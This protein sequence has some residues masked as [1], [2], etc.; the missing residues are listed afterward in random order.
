M[1]TSSTGP[2]SKI[3]ARGVG[4]V[5]RNGAAVVEALRKISFAVSPN[6]FVVLLGPSGCGKSTLLRL[7]A[8]FEQP[9]TGELLVDGHLVAGTDP[10]RGIV[11]QRFASFPWL[12]VERNIE[13]GLKIL[14]INRA[15]RV[16]A[17]RQWI[18]VTG[19]QGFEKSY[20]AALSAGMQQ[21]VALARTLATKPD[22]LLLD[23]PFAAL[24]A[25]TRDEMQELLLEIWAEHSTTILF[26]THD[27]RE[28]VYLAD[29]VLVMS[30]RPSTIQ[31]DMKVDLPRPRQR[32]VMFSSPFGRI[33]SELLNLIRSRASSVN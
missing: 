28:A 9:S 15:E 3:E 10:R 12:T 7:I 16:A 4:K 18:Q 19:L 31:K 25:Q 21:R 17:V 20:P 8:G 6:E 22:I 5:F 26:V 30:R 14:G 1:S 13:F 27:V 33:E 29:R 32:N 2:G 23:E 24:D 11:F